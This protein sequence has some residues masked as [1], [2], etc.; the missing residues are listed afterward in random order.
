MGFQARIRRG[1]LYVGDLEIGRSCW[2][3]KLSRMFLLFLVAEA[4]SSD[5][6]GSEVMRRLRQYESEC[7][8]LVSQTRQDGDMLGAGI[9]ARGCVASRTSS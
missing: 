9:N 4:A 3:W 8:S 2:K 6:E 1:S 5:V 7:R